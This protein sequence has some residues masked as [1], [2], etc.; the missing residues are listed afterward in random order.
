MNTFLDWFNQLDT[1]GLLQLLEAAAYFD[2]ESYNSVFRKELE[3]LLNRITDEGARQEIMDLRT[4]DFSNYILNSLKR[5]GIRDD[6]SVQEAFHEI[7]VRLLVSPGKLF[8]G[9]VPGKHGPLSRRVRASIWNNIRN[10]ISKQR[11]W[12]KR[13]QTADPVEI[14]ERTPGRESPSQ[15]IIDLFRKL[16]RQRLGELA[17]AILDQRLAGKETK[18]LVGNVEF[19]T[20]SAF[21]VKRT[22]GEIKELADRFAA[23]IGDSDFANLVSRA[24][25]RESATIEKRK[26]AM[27]A[28]QAQ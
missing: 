20:P 26:I 22:V 10:L 17:L 28:R 19:G 13:F 9:W 14:A 3:E 6:D 12:R 1:A 27:A 11:N 15:E 18:N 4:F 21:S 7:V 16:V 8:K 24:M 5:A 23:K 2:P 25:E